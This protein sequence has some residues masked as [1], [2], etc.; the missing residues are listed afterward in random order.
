MFCISFLLVEFP[1]IGGALPYTSFRTIRLDRYQGNFAY[2]VLA[3]EVIYVAFLLY[4]TYREGKQLWKK[5]KDYFG[6]VWNLLE[7]VT[8]VLAYA[9]ISFYLYRLFIGRRLVNQYRED[10]ESF[11]NFQY[12]AHWD[13]MYGYMTG[14]V[15]FIANLK[16]MKLLRFNRRLLLLSMTLKSAGYDIL[17]YLV[18]FGIVFMAFSTMAFAMYNAYLVSFSS[19]GATIE[20]LFSTLLG[21]FKFHEML[22]ASRYLGPVF[23]F[24]YVVVIMFIC[25]N[26]FLSIINEAFTQ[27]RLE[28]ARAE[29]EL[30]IVDFMMD[31]FKK[32]VG[33]GQPDG[34]ASQRRKKKKKEETPYY[35]IEDEDPVEIECREI[36]KKTEKMM[37]LLESYL[38]EHQSPDDAKLGK[39][40]IIVT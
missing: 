9:A 15:V 40:R 1:A 24:C 11:M 37:R 39:R 6:S 12:I 29:N 7:V 32:W 34:P 25:L 38:K 27:V 35:C 2:F 14:L 21:K 5:K 31:R 10:P 28:N 22:Q 33:L 26:M 17:H 23:F 13:L 4:F 30:E 16:F 20:T 18:V 36:E 19:F 8:L 3:G